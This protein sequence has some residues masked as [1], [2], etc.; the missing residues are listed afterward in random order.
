[1]PFRLMERICPFGRM[2][3][4]PP[5]LSDT[6]LTGAGRFTFLAIA[7]LGTPPTFGPAVLPIAEGV[8]VLAPAGPLPFPFATGPALFLPDTVVPVLPEVLT[9]PVLADA[10][11][12][13]VLPTVVPGLIAA[14]VPGLPTVGVGCIAVD[15][16]TFEDRE[17]GALA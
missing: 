5:P 17:A 7:P 11:P 8:P 9:D 3:A 4:I 10:V 14:V 2:V 15:G 6:C 13:P 1:M 12:R 16:R